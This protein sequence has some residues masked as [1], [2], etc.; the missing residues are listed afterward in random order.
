MATLEPPLSVE[1]VAELLGIGRRQAYEAVR[2]GQIP[3][4]RIGH[5]I[6]VPRAGLE[7]LLSVGDPENAA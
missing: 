1:A 5:R 4:V 3:S 7:R 2:N 6:L